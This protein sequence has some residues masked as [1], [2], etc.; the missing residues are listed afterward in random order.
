MERSNARTMENF[1]RMGIADAIR[2]AGLDN[3]MPMDVFICRE[4][5]QKTSIVHHEYPSVNALKAAYREVTDGTT[6]A[7]P[8]QLI[9]QYTLEPLLRD[10]AAALRA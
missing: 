4:T 7:E 3:D 8:Y 9:S 2:A 10:V 6:A 5:L 1:R